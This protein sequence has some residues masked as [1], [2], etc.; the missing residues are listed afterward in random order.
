MEKNERYIFFKEYTGNVKGSA[1]IE[2]TPF[3]SIAVDPNYHKPGDIFIIIDKEDKSKKFLAIAHDTG[4]AIKGKNRID[5][6][7]GYGKEPEKIAATMKKEIL[8]WKLS[9]R[10]IVS[11]GLTIF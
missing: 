6:F 10:K 2:L 3:V 9:P 5:I 11:E 7:T 4:A 8:I 1:S